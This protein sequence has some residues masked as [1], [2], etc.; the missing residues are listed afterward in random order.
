MSSPLAA[1]LCSSPR[2]STLEHQ[3]LHLSVRR[4]FRVGASACQAFERPCGINQF[5]RLFV[6][7]CRGW[8]SDA[9]DPARVTA[10]RDVRGGRRCGVC[11]FVRHDVARSAWSNLYLWSALAPQERHSQMRRTA[12]Q[13]D[14]AN[15]A[16]RG[17]CRCRRRS[18]TSERFAVCLRGSRMQA[19]DSRRERMATTKVV[20]NTPERGVLVAT[21]EEAS[22]SLLG[23]SEK[24]GS[25]LE[26]GG[27]VSVPNRPSIG[28]YRLTHRASCACPPVA[29]P[30]AR[31]RPLGGRQASSVPPRCWGTRCWLRIESLQSD[32]AH[33]VALVHRTRFVF[34]RR[35]V[36]YQQAFL[37]RLP[38]GGHACSMVG[39]Q[40]AV[41]ARYA[42]RGCSW[43]GCIASP[44]PDCA[45]QVESFPGAQES[46]R[47]R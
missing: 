20:N 30:L 36:E 1:G 47:W 31:S 16:A 17:R 2:P 43:D 11:C 38:R 25:E 12:S 10:P 8:G 7:L 34:E 9:E 37:V 5:D 27:Q 42:A 4:A 21:S 32:G 19:F 39:Q 6:Y 29:S 35:W 44:C 24:E 40:A 22:R 41:L 23:E 3:P 26:V 15:R 46:L 18:L 14:T 28:M 33:L 45:G 13:S